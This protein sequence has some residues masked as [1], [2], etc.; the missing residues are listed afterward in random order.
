MSAVP[1]G[2]L[3]EAWS[4][5]QDRYQAGR[6]EAKDRIVL[7]CARELAADPG[8]ESAHQWVFGL[9]M[10]L[11]YV[12]W[13]PGD[14]VPGAVLEAAR[15]ADVALKDRTCAHEGHPY[16]EDELE[17]HLFSLRDVL[18]ASADESAEWDEGDR[19][20]DEWL[21]PLNA[22]GFARIAM[23]YIEPG[24]A[25][26]IPA[27]LPDD[28]RRDIDSL[29]AILHGYPRPG[30]D[31]DLEIS[32]VG[33]DLGRATDPDDR[34]GLVIA[35]T[36]VSWYALSDIPCAHEAHP[37]LP[38]SGPDAVWVGLHLSSAAG[39][40]V[41]EKERQSS[42]WGAPLDTLLCPSFVTATARDT[43]TRLRKK[44]ATL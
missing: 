11:P 30:T 22:A 1:I 9:V 31:V 38:S 17:D 10:M 6:D 35:T 20:L 4:E 42:G 41:Y 40:E 32:C 5:V 37:G 3:A 36:A 13:L 18:S 2:E 12:G 43:L 25:D 27:R 21:C 7:D 14:G 33:N 44:R 8:G 26:G 16:E 23:D 29:S 39:R 19:P 28:T 34:A 24:S 15:A